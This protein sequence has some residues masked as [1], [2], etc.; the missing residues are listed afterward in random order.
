MAC[1]VYNLYIFSFMSS[2]NN[3]FSSLF[4]C[5]SCKGN[6]LNTVG[7]E[8]GNKK[9]QIQYINSGVYFLKQVMHNESTNTNILYSIFSCIFPLKYISCG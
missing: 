5:P 2:P 3:F 7:D 8:W 4:F 9:R 6:I 1:L